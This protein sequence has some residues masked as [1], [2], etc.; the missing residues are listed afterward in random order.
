[1][2]IFPQQVNGKG[3]VLNLALTSNRSQ[4]LNS[5]MAFQSIPNGRGSKE[6]S[7]LFVVPVILPEYSTSLNLT[8]RN[9]RV[10]DA[11]DKIV[12]SFQLH[13]LIAGMKKVF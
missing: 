2:L 11:L 12:S 13:I 4:A 8:E 6:V 5:V 9:V 3:R 7:V 1:M 10:C